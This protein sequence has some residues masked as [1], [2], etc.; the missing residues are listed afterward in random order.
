M[1]F[2]MSECKYVMDIFLAFYDLPIPIGSDEIF[3]RLQIWLNN[4]QCGHKEGQEFPIFW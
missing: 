2:M 3:K 4:S 1:N